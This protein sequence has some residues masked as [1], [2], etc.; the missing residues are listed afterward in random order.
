MIIVIK[1]KRRGHSWAFEFSEK[2]RRAALTAVGGLIGSVTA[3]IHRV[4][5]PPEGDTLI[6]ATAELLEAQNGK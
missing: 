4:A 1:P 5:L 3:V 6:S 2:R